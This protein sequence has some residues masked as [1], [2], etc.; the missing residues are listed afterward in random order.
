MR[1]APTCYE[2]AFCFHA[3]NISLLTA[4]IKSGPFYGGF[5]LSALGTF[6]SHHQQIRTE[7]DPPF[8]GHAPACFAHNKLFTIRSIFLIPLPFLLLHSVNKGTAV[9]IQNRSLYLPG[10]RVNYLLVFCC[11]GFFSV[12]AG[13]RLNG[14]WYLWCSTYWCC[15]ICSRWH[16]ANTEQA[17]MRNCMWEVSDQTKGPGH[18]GPHCPSQ[19][20]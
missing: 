11:W 4:A 1:S 19:K 17:V 10:N 15:R 7:L 8:L 3:K 20:T 13:D 6:I 2:F 12:L 16:W 9:T 5:F 18:G 14:Y